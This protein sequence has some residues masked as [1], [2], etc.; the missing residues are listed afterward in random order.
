MAQWD[1]HVFLPYRYLLYA[2]TRLG[3]LVHVWQLGRKH[4]TPVH[5]HTQPIALNS[6]TIVPVAILTD[7]YSYVVVDTVSGVAVLIDPSDPQTVM[8]CPRQTV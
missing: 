6:V 8:V 4:T 5:S 1:C 7:N 2:K 3:Y